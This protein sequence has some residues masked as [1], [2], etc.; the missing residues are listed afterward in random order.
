MPITTSWYDEDHRVVVQRYV[1]KYTWEEF[2]QEAENTRTLANS[3][4]YNLVLLIDES[5]SNFMPSGNVLAN[6]RSAMTGMP[7]NYT[8]VIVV[9]QSRLVEVFANL[10]FEMMPRY[11]SRM[12]IVKTVE[13]G[14][15]LV[16]EAIAKNAVG[17][18]VK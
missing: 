15:K 8:Q 2:S 13:E 3:V 16:A 11:R 18:P 7:E 17:S 5:Q 6:G 9:I 10:L 12:K 14:E 4:P 1:G